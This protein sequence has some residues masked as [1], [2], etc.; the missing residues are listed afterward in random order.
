MARLKSTPQRYASY[1]KKYLYRRVAAT[2]SLRPQKPFPER[3]APTSD[4]PVRCKAGVSAEHCKHVEL[5][6]EAYKAEPRKTI[7]GGTLHLVR[8]TPTLKIYRDADT[9]LYYV[10][11]RG[12]ASGEDVLTDVALAAGGLRLTSRWRQDRDELQKFL[13]E[14]PSARLGFAGHSLGGALAR[15]LSREFRDQSIGGATFNSAFDATQLTPSAHGEMINYFTRA[16]ILGK[17]APSGHTLRYLSTDH[18]DPLSA[19]KLK[20]FEE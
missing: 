6:E 15:E 19:H 14:T 16:D 7:R 8:H 20:A 4:P 9:D 13:S 10:A 2:P 12:T 17:L 3:E 5:A 18:F 1:A 11:S